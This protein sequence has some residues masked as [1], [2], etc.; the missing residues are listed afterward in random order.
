MTF[1]QNAYSEIESV[2]KNLFFFLPSFLRVLCIMQGKPHLILFPNPFSLSP[3]LLV[4]ILFPL[5]SLLYWVGPR[6]GRNA[7]KWNGLVHFCQGQGLPI[8]T[9]SQNWLD[10]LL[11]VLSKIKNWIPLPTLGQILNCWIL[12][13]LQG[14]YTL[15]HLFQIGLTSLQGTCVS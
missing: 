14:A 2:N 10:F 9:Q 12:L 1:F 7:N 11:T 8:A 13:W 4:P 15:S 5:T 3:A 6:F